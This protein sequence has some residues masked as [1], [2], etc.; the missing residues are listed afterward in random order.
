M[1]LFIALPAPLQPLPPRKVKPSRKQEQAGS[2]CPSKQDWEGKNPGKALWQAG[3]A[4]PQHTP[5]P[6][7]PARSQPSEQKRVS[8][9]RA[10][11]LSSLCPARSSELT[12]SAFIPPAPCGTW[13]RRGGERG[14]QMKSRPRKQFLLPPTASFPPPFAPLPVSAGITVC[15]RAQEDGDR[16]SVV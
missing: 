6:P 15:L 12:G 8:M 13:E 9:P 16:K 14:T 2:S 10:R 1:E 4:P 11:R 7:H 5:T 3:K